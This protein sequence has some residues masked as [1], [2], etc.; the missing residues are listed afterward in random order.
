LYDSV[1]LAGNLSSQQSAV[2]SQL[3][4]PCLLNKKMEIKIKI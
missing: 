3:S 4:A 1:K 2:S